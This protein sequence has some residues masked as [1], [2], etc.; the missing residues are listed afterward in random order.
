M[1]SKFVMTGQDVVDYMNDS[2]NAIASMF[3]RQNKVNG[4][5][6][7][8]LLLSGVSVWILYSEICQLRKEIEEMKRPE[9]E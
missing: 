2:L 3:K 7:C 1:N 9:G 5:T 4:L 8:S 6:A